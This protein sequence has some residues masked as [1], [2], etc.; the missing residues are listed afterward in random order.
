MYNWQTNNPATS[1][2]WLEA[3]LPFLKDA[4]LGKYFPSYVTN[5]TINGGQPN[6]L[7]ALLWLGGAL[8]LA[9]LLIFFG[10]GKTTEPPTYSP[11]PEIRVPLG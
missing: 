8:L 1:L 10:E 7:A 11:Q 6:V 3:N 9:G 4:S 5:L 2:R